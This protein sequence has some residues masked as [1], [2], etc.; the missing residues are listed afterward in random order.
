MAYCCEP[1]LIVL[2]FFEFLLALILRAALDTIFLFTSPIWYFIE[3]YQSAS[4][5]PKAFHSVVI[6]GA[7]GGIGRAVAIE[8]A[9]RN[10]KCTL[11][12]LG[13]N[14]DRLRE[15]KQL[16]LE[17]M[18][19]S[20]S[21]VYCFSADMTNKEQVQQVMNKCDDIRPVDLIFANAGISNKCTSSDDWFDRF[22]ELLRVNVLGTFNCVFP[23]LKRMIKRK[24]GHI[25]INASVASY[26]PLFGS[27][28]VYSATKVFLRFMTQT[29]A[30]SL[31]YYGVDC[32][33]INLGWVDTP[34]IPQGAQ[35]W[36]VSAEDTASVIAN[37]LYRNKSS[38][39]FPFHF[40]FL[41][42]YVGGLHPV[43]R[44]CIAWIAMPGDAEPN[45]VFSRYLG[46]GV[47]EE[48]V[49]EDDRKDERKKERAPLMSPNED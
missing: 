2:D 27:T 3:A 1:Y 18:D 26:H 33:V 21:S 5:G 47:S 20:Q 42:W 25:A 39:E 11:F 41:M 37:G 10:T 35:R 17:H 8:F 28:S 4:T 48:Y 7:S 44:Q 32:T 34:L 31:M 49:D 12:L 36:S 16:C 6:T 23:V 24:R 46:E 14:T 13:R 45:H 9:Q 29:L 15:T 38:I 40:S 22:D 19:D 43:F 30:V